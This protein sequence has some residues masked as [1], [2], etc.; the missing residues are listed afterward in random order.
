[1]TLTKHSPRRREAGYNLVILVMAVAILNIMV[2][3]M[4]PLWSTQ[5]RREKEEELIFRGLQYAE[6]IRIFQNRFQRL[7]TKLDEL[8]EVKPRC[9]R[10]LWKDPMTEGGKW[11]V[12]YQGQGTPLV[13]LPGQPLVPPGQ[14]GQP[15]GRAGTRQNT[16]VPG[17]GGGE[18]PETVATG[19]IIGVHSRSTKKSIETWDGKDEYDQW[20]FTFNLITGVGATVPLI[21]GRPQLNR[22]LKLDVRWIGRPFPGLPAGFQP[23]GGGLPGGPGSAVP[24]PGLPGIGVPAPIGSPRRPVGPPGFPGGVPGPPGAKP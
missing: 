16:P 9:I 4:L 23:A 7:P 5:I 20:N 1:M 18:Q 3:A 12:I 2:V 24:F 8:V 10:Q 17:E 6:A 19:P 14:P 21:P 11:A 22:G 15:N 13:P